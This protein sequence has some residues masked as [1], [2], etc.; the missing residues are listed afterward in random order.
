MPSVRTHPVGGAVQGSGWK[1]GGSTNLVEGCFGGRGAE[2]REQAGAGALEHDADGADLHGQIDLPPPPP[3]K[4][5]G[6]VVKTEHT[7]A[8]GGAEEAV[9]HHEA[10]SAVRVTEVAPGS[11]RRYVLAN[12]AMSG[13]I[14]G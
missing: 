3:G 2:A 6:K 14:R 1:G 12:L 11:V 9:A 8:R 7:V 5:G 13:R 10:G 4:S